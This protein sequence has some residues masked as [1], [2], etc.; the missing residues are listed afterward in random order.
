METADKKQKKYEW[1]VCGR[2]GQVNVLKG[3]ELTRTMAVS[4][5]KSQGI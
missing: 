4:G 1:F 2:K 5:S 3:R